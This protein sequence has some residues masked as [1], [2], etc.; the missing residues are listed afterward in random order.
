[1]REPQHLIANGRYL[2]VAEVER[3][4]RVPL[5][6]GVRMPLREAGGLARSVGLGAERDYFL[7]DERAED[8]MMPIAPIRI[9]EQPEEQENIADTHAVV[10][11][12]RLGGAGLTESA[13]PPLKHRIMM[14][15]AGSR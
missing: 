4:V 13:A 12:V 1:M 15:K 11:E 7:N 5:P 3:V 10:L 6:D 8:P 9:G 14:A 2:S